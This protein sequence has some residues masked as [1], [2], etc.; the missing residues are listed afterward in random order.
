MTGV[1]TC[2]LPILVFVD[3]LI[4]VSVIIFILVQFI[5]IA[6]YRKDLHTQPELQEK[7]MRLPADAQITDHAH[8]LNVIVMLTP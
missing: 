1:Q 2:A 3:N 8:L 6:L 5:L 7:I 4:L